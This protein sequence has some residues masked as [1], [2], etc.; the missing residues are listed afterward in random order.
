MICCGI[1]PGAA[2]GLAVFKNGRLIEMHTE[3]PWSV[4]DKLKSFAPDLIVI[5]DSRLISKLFMEGTYTNRGR[6]SVPQKLKIARDIGSIDYQCAHIVKW[7]EENGI[8]VMCISPKNKGAKMDADLF[9]QRYGWEGR[10]NI[11][12]RDAA[13]VAYPYRHARLQNRG[14]ICH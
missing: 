14:E 2:T 13:L 6:L 9:R 4:F 12:E 3:T 11:H 5:E 1:D 7:S 8:A 10:S